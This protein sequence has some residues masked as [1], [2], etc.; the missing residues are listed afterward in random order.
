VTEKHQMMEGRLLVFRRPQSR[1][2]Q[3]STYLAGKELRKSTKQESFAHAKD[4][5]EK[6]FLGLLGKF[7]GG[8]IK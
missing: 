6:W 1:Y 7:H 3:C 5:A 2:W 8:E 4:F